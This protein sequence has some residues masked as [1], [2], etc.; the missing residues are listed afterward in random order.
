MKKFIW[1]QSALLCSVLFLC[2]GLTTQAKEKN[3]IHDGVYLG[4]VDASGLSVEDARAALEEY[5][6][7]VG[8]SVMTLQIDDNQV[9]VTLNELGLSCTNMDVVEEALGL[10]KSG[11]IIKRF[12]EKKELERSKK[13]Y[14]LE[15]TVNPELVSQVIEG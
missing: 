6:K 10:G 8:D 14:E 13:V 15:W 11:D 12:K 5:T 2:M 4:E 9:Q 3:M 1:L 7:V